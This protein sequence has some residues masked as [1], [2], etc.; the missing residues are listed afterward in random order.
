MQVRLPGGR[1]AAGRDLPLLGRTRR[2]DSVD[3]VMAWVRRLA[4]GGEAGRS[5]GN[6]RVDLARGSTS[7]SATFCPAE[8]VM[9]LS[10]EVPRQQFLRMGTFRNP[11]SVAAR[12]LASR[13]KIVILSTP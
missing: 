10:S 2:D 11:R 5:S 13:S 4:S 12:A 8:T 9:S 1:E 3:P 6:K 7:T